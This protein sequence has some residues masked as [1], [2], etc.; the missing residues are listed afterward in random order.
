MTL[1]DLLDDLS[2]GAGVGVGLGVV[3]GDPSVV[4]RESALDRLR[5]DGETIRGHE[6][7]ILDVLQHP[8]GRVT[9]VVSKITSSTSVLRCASII[10]LTWA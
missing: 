6:G 4:L 9:R 1:E 8:P 3:P 10:Q 7:V 5:Q 2:D